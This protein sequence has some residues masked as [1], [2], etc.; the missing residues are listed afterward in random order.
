MTGLGSGEGKQTS[1]FRQDEQDSQGGQE[2][3]NFE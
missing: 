2:G 3:G 1:I